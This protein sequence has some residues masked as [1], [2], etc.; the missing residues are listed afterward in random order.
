MLPNGDR[1]SKCPRT[2]DPESP[3]RSDRGGCGPRCGPAR[4]V[5]DRPPCGLTR[6]QASIQ[7]ESDFVPVVRAH[8]VMGAAGGASMTDEAWTAESST[9]GPDSK[10]QSAAD[11]TRI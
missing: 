5:G 6:D 3:E 4:Q 10:G 8:D 7:V 2:I 11:A 1:V 9:C